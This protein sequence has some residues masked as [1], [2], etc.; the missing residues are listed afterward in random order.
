M[1]EC[2]CV[3]LCV[4]RRA[5]RFLCGISTS[6]R[7]TCSTQPS[8]TPRYSSRKHPIPPSILHPVASHA[9]PCS[10]RITSRP[11]PPLSLS[12][13]LSICPFLPFP[14]LREQV[15]R[16]RGRQRRRAVPVGPHVR[17]RLRGLLGPHRGRAQEAVQEAPP[18]EPA[19]LAHLRPHLRSNPHPLS[20]YG[21]MDLC[22]RIYI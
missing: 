18:A 22:H 12:Q 4:R 11:P 9:M 2:V 19:L 17:G 10:N 5:S 13:T 6:P 8:S 3:C 7:P 14:V 20:I 1:N 16:R 15:W 21:E